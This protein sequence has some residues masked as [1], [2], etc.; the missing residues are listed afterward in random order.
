MMRFVVI[1]FFSFCVNVLTAQVTVGST[2][3]KDTAR[4]GERISINFKVV[5]RGNTLNVKAIDY[6]PLEELFSIVSTDPTTDTIDTS[7]PADFEWIS[8]RVDEKFI[9]KQADFTKTNEGL[10]YENKIDFIVWDMGVFDIPNPNIEVDSNSNTRVNTLQGSRLFVLPPEGVMPQDTTEAIMPIIPIIA[11]PVTW[12]DYMWIAYIAGVILLALLLI[13]LFLRYQRKKNEEPEIEEIIIRPAHIIANEKL[14]ELDNKQLWQ[15]GD[16]KG[17]QSELTYIIREY[18]ENRYEI[19]ALESTTG[20]IKR[21]LK[22]ANFD[23]AHEKKLLEILQIADM[24]KFAKAKPSDNIHQAFMDDAKSFVKATQ[25]LIK[26]DND[27]L[28]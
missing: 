13:W 8:Q 17:Y 25:L 2:V 19:Q 10:V 22:A 28:V 24:V 18:L 26:E 11:E 1:L 6:A 4:I 16:I 7:T 14:N 12:R 9:L 23:Q 15:S 27:E 5:N 21:D 3:T 20:E